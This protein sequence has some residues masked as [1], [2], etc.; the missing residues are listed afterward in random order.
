M[1]FLL[2]FR[3]S[4]NGELGSEY[5]DSNAPMAMEWG[6]GRSAI[7]KNI[8]QLLLL[9]FD[10]RIVSDRFLISARFSSLGCFGHVVVVVVVVSVLAPSFLFNH[11]ILRM[12]G[13]GT[14]ML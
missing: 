13:L 10:E 5:R 8:K 2:L 6:V 11:D 1:L 7:V 12:I 9:I 4:I 3:Q 14:L